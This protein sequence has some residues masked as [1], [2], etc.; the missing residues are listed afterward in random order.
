MNAESPIF[1]AV[2]AALIAV[3][4]TWSL[5]RRRPVY[6]AGETLTNLT[7]A[8]GNGLIRPIAVIWTFLV[9]SWIEP[10]QRV[11]LPD[12][13]WAFPLTFVVVDFAYYGYHRAS[14]ELRWLWSM[15]HTHHSS[16]WY[17]LSTAVRLN[18]VAKFV[19]PLF[20]AP[21]VLVGL[22]AEA[23]ASVSYTHLRAHET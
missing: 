12:T 7:I 11:A 14:H 19:S 22:S 3:E 10:V 2:F 9:M 1:L 13:S 16:P 8:L 5:V 23:V 20:F 21:L 18:W 6:S 17:N 4:L 15:H